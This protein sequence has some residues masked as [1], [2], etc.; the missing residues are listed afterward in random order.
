LR[1]VIRLAVSEFV[2]QCFAG[3]VAALV[4]AGVVAVLLLAR[5]RRARRAAARAAAAERDLHAA[6]RPVQADPTHRNGHGGG[7]PISSSSG[8]EWPPG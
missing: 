3:V 2:V 4:F 7:P 1:V 8:D 6:A 5:F